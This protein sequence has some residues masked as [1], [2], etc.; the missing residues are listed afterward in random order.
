MVARLDGAPDGGASR[1]TGTSTSPSSRWTRRSRRRVSW[2]H[3]NQRSM[4]TPI[5]PM[6]TLSD[7]QGA[8]FSLFQPSGETA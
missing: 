5:G 8:I 2:G 7:P 1:T 4:T 6:A 3:G